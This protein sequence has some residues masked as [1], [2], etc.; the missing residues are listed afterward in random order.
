MFTI[1]MHYAKEDTQCNGDYTDVELFIDGIMVAKAGDYYHD[2]GDSLMTG[3]V[4]GWAKAKGIE[5]V[6]IQYEHIADR[7]V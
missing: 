1:K 2:K 3:F 6:D 5:N 7:D 4:N